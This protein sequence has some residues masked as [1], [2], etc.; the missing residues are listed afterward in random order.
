[1]RMRM[2]SLRLIVVMVFLCEQTFTLMC[3]LILEK[4]T[5]VQFV[6]VQINCLAILF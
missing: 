5:F 1:M 4:I 3:I 2:I 6:I